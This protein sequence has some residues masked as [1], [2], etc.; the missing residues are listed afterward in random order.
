VEIY[1]QL[2]LGDVV[3]MR[4]PHPCGGYQ[5]EIVRVGADI[6][7]CCLTCNRRVLLP[8]RDFARRAK[9]FLKR[10]PAATPATE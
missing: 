8:R 6:G 9:R 3:E 10:G 7:L 5:W 1:E 4:K 2:Y